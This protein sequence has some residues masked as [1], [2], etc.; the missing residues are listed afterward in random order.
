MLVLRFVCHTCG[1]IVTTI[2]LNKD[3]VECVRVFLT[4]CNECIKDEDNVD[5]FHENIDPERNFHI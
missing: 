1:K 3:G 2:C 5:A 4:L